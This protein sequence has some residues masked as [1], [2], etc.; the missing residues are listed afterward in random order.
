MLVSLH[1]RRGNIFKDL[2]QENET[3]LLKLG[4]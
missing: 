2:R 3:K 4:Y 1:Y